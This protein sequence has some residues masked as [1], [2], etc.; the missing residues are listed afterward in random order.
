MVN[1]N[2]RKRTRLNSARKTQDKKLA[3]EF[4]KYKIAQKAIEKAESLKALEN[5]SK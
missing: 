1:T 4:E 2:H 5:D 3:A